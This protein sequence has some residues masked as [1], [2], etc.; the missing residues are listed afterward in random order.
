MA[1]R[2]QDVGRTAGSTP[3]TLGDVYATAYSRWVE[4]FL[5]HIHGGGPQLGRLSLSETCWPGIS[6]ARQHLVAPTVQSLLHSHR[7]AQRS[8]VVFLTLHLNVRQRLDVMAGWHR[9]VLSSLLPSFLRDWINYVSL[10]LLEVSK[11]TFP[12]ISHQ[13][14]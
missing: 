2:C 11:H 8:H 6:P 7:C 9:A 1:T 14:M 13:S 12:V 3:R 5:L 10:T 4:F